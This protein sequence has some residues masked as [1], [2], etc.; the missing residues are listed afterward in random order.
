MCVT[1]EKRETFKRSSSTQPPL[2]QWWKDV[3]VGG[4]GLF[5]IFDCLTSSFEET[6]W[7]LNANTAF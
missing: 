7:Q 2:L 3:C 1:T 5:P 6:Y 4:G